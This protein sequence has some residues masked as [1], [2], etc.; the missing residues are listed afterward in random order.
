M[1]G[2]QPLR[3]VDERPLLALRQRLPL[4][5]EPL[6]DFG[7]VHLWILLR[8]LPP[9]APGPD[10]ERVHR[11]LHAVRVVLVLLAALVVVALDVVVVRRRR[12]LAA[13]SCRQRRRVLRQLRV[14]V[15]AEVL[16]AHLVVRRG[17]RGRWRKIGVTITRINGR[18]GTSVVMMGYSPGC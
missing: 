7:V 18:R 2:P 1:Q 10:H 5:P 11:P 16:V 13:R 8:H 15:V 4:R 6:R 14:V 17:R 9:L 12:R 3:L